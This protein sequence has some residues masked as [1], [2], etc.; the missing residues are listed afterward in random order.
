[1]QS[2]LTTLEDRLKD[3]RAENETLSTQLVDMKNKQKDILKY[4]DVAE[5]LE[6]KVCLVFDY[7]THNSKKSHNLFSL[8]QLKKMEADN[9]TTEV[10]LSDLASS[11]T[12]ATKR[13]KEEKEECRNL[14]EQ[15]KEQNI[16]REKEQKLLTSLQGD[17]Q[18]AEDYIL[19]LQRILKG[20]ETDVRNALAEKDSA[21]SHVV[22]FDKREDELNRRLRVMDEVR[23]DLHNKVMR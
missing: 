12:Q 14:S 9:K 17:L 8:L 13:Y 22:K 10:Q 16:L 15:L 5:D 7:D 6:A 4:K 20:K 3:A 18:K 11:L 23:R 19:K 2:H 21:V 1:M